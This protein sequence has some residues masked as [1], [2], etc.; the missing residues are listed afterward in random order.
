MC[1]PGSEPYLLP[2][3]ERPIL[4]GGHHTQLPPQALFG[5]CERAPCPRPTEQHRGQVDLTGRDDSSPEQET[6][7]EMLKSLLA[8]NQPQYS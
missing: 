8:Q 5:Q 4:I 3:P 7:I 1:G 2:P 6:Q